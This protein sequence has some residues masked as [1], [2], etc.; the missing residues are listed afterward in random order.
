MDGYQGWF[1]LHPSA[2]PPR[3]RERAVEVLFVPLL[4]DE[5]EQVFE[6]AR[7]VPQILPEDEHLAELIARG[8]SVREIAA[9]LDLAPRTV[10]RRVARLR[11]KVGVAS[12]AELRAFLSRR[13]F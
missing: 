6:G 3:W 5:V 1:F 4:P 11:E 12:T 9:E 7:A 13:G 10:E 2:V 8:I